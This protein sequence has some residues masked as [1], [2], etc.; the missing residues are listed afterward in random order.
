M[1][2]P[3]GS[4]RAAV[5]SYR[6]LRTAVGFIGVALPPILA[7]GCRLCQHH[8]LEPSLSAYYYTNMGNYFV[9]SLAAIGVFLAFTRGYGGWDVAAGWI[10]GV[11]AIGVALFPTKPETCATPRQITISNIHH[12]C[13]GVL[14]IVLGLMS[15]FLFRKTVSKE[16]RTERKKKRD[17]VYLVCGVII[18]VCVAALGVLHWTAPEALS[19]RPYPE[20]CLETIAIEAFGL[21]W[22]TKGETFSF[23]R[24]RPPS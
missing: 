7:L 2:A 23:I 19:A 22:L 17:V 20:F 15:L 5:L 13:A 12:T 18:L 6:E 11:C 3:P 16:T 24:D 1:L 4:E 9:G 10:A 14:F 8:W 21:A